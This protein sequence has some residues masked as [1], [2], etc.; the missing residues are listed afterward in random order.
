MKRLFLFSTI[1][2]CFGFFA[3][4][5]TTTVING[6]KATFI[7][8]DAAK[9]GMATNVS[10]NGRYVVGEFGSTAGFVYDVVD[11]TFYVFPD[12][13]T[14]DVA[15][16][17]TIV[18]TIIKDGYEHVAIYKNG[19]WTALPSYPGFNPDD[20]S[21]YSKAATAYGLSADGRVATGMAYYH[22]ESYTPCGGVNWI[23]G[24]FAYWIHP[25][26]PFNPA[27][28]TYGAQAYGAR[29]NG[30][31][32]DGRT[33]F[34]WGAYPPYEQRAPHIWRDSVAY[35]VG[36]NTN[37]ERAGEVW[38][39]NTNGSVLGGT[40][41]RDGVLWTRTETGYTSEKLAAPPGWI[42]STLFSIS[43]S[44]VAVGMLYQ[45]FVTD[46]GGMV[47][48]R[49]TGMLPVNTYLK[50]LYGLTVPGKYELGTPDA[51]SS[52]GKVIAGWGASEGD[53]ISYVIL[54]EDEMI[55]PRPSG[56]SA[57]QQRETAFVKV[58]WQ[59]PINSGREVLGYNIYRDG[60]K[61]NASIVTELTYQDTPPTGSRSYAVT[62]VYASGE[63]EQSEAFNVQ[64]VAVGGCYAVQRVDVYNQYNRNITVA[65]GLSSDI[66]EKANAPV[67]SKNSKN[68]EPNY[69][70]DGPQKSQSK[71]S[72][73]SLVDLDY[74]RTLDLLSHNRYTCF[75]FKGLYYSGAHS[76]QGISVL[77]ESGTL[78]KTIDIPGTGTVIALTT[79]GTDVYAAC[80]TNRIYEIDI[81]GTDGIR[82][83]I[84]LPDTMVKSIQHLAY[85]PSLDGGRGGFE[86]GDWTSS[87]FIDKSG[88]YLSDGISNSGDIAGTTYYGGKIYSHEQVG[89]G[90]SLIREYDAVT[91]QPTGLSIQMWKNLVL[92]N[93][94][95]PFEDGV[96][97]SISCVVM[98][99]ST[100]CLI[101]VYQ[102]TNQQNQ[103][104]FLEFKKNP[105]LKGYNVYRNNEKINTELLQ[106]R[107]IQEELYEAGT[108]NYTVSAEFVNGC[109]SDTITYTKTTI[110]PI[111]GVCS[112]VKDLQAI[113][114]KGEAFLS[115]DMPDSYL[116][117]QI[118]GFNIFRDGVKINDDFRIVSNYTD[119]EATEATHVY[120]VE[121]YYDNS[122]TASDSVEITL[123]GEGI[124]GAPVGLRLT[125]TPSSSGNMHDVTAAWSLPYFEHPYPLYYGE[126]VA[127]TAIGLQDG[128][129]G[130]AAVGW[131]TTVLYMYEG[132]SLGGIEFFIQDRADIKPIVILDEKIVYHEPFDGEIYESSYNRIMFDE[133]VSLDNIKELVVGYT[134]SNYGAGNRPFGMAFGEAVWDYGDLFSQTPEDMT[135][136]YP[137]SSAELPYN[138]AITALLVKQREIST[139]ASAPAKRGG[140]L[141]NRPITVEKPKLLAK[142]L[143]HPQYANNAKKLTG[144]NLYRNGQQVNSEIIKSTQ[145]VDL[146]VGPGRYEYAVSSLW[147]VCDGVVGDV[148]DY[149]LEDVA[150]E[151]AT[152]ISAIRLYP[153]PAT[154]Y[155]MVEGEYVSAQIT[156]MTGRTVKTVSGNTS[157]ISVRGF[158][159]GA[160]LLRLTLSNN[161][162]STF[163]LFIR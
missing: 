41:G 97:G 30:I 134:A 6:T 159:S 86:V 8:L 117:G 123:N 95:I 154:E 36:G 89:L 16:D 20:F 81:E 152:N 136:W 157:K 52:D 73:D 62:A 53:Y 12:V 87:Y 114:I 77:D 40:I 27:Q 14:K 28:G 79:D 50:E 161:K 66:I 139:E 61:I 92:A 74:V 85:I 5:Q 19:V 149:T 35:Y 130:T 127:I 17:M 33:T 137:V 126:A 119:R 58:T 31:S 90:R 70:Y 148:V 106:R 142:T 46:R 21:D 93:I 3:L 98:E 24:Q 18:G 113:E 51:I 138:F 71:A 47:W 38:C 122:C 120:R 9:G 112:P 82:N 80:K 78:I 104:I 88:T 69:E 60:V 34:G 83:S 59:K 110:K 147:N 162:I 39:S 158:A 76:Q 56:V 140:S 25:A 72:T 124:C 153:N 44:G 121:S 15:D 94:G 10:S 143:D 65:W 84:A 4:A 125:S 102:V 151:V 55:N 57:R 145:Y 63:S 131:D 155:V 101:P 68:A 48:S 91:G 96:A 141:L 29:A 11:D 128:L 67:A 23:D 133:P 100:V 132:Y 160:Y 156:D 115:F 22:R 43:D 42:S 105:K 129:A 64:V 103:A 49:K 109:V 45:A 32:A 1:A 2:A 75:P 99:D 163:K 150:N 116:Y 144:F 107:Y 54:L 135:S 7:S 26:F 118:V 111:L 37:E 146:G 108:Y 13:H